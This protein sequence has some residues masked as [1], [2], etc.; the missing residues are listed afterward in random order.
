MGKLV[1]MISKPV[2]LATKTN[3]KLRYADFSKMECPE[4][5][6][7]RL[8][9]ILLAKRIALMTHVC[10]CRNRRWRPKQKT[11]VNRLLK[12]LIESDHKTQDFQE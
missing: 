11:S 2:D 6:V 3:L 4:S 1:T 10:N 12:S 9:E 7:N 8:C 5:P